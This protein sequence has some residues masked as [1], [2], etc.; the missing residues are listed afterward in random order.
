MLLSPCTFIVPT[1]QN[2][3]LD[4]MRAQE[5]KAISSVNIP[6]FFLVFLYNSLSTKVAGAKA[7]FF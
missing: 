1:V 2:G 3:P 6:S 7:D 4:N 5:R